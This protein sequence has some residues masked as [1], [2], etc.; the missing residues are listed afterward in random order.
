M[1]SKTI[2]KKD[3][4][5]INLQ[6]IQNVAE[7]L[8]QWRLKMGGTSPPLWK[9]LGQR[10]PFNFNFQEYIKKYFICDAT[11]SLKKGFIIK[12]YRNC[13]FDNTPSLSWIFSKGPYSLCEIQGRGGG[14]TYSE[15]YKIMEKEQHIKAILSV[16]TVHVK[17]IQK[18]KLGLIQGFKCI[19]GSILFC[20]LDS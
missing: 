3:S 16:S 13:R 15:I 19:T 1:Y 8:K 9:N 4:H 5:K 12:I 2:Y 14:S 18:Q 6:Y 20:K 7:T 11:L 10:E 17:T